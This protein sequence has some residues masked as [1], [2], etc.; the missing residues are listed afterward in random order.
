MTEPLEAGIGREARLAKEE[1]SEGVT[2]AGPAAA[3][4]VMAAT[5]A[6]EN[7]MLTVG[8]VDRNWKV[9]EDALNKVCIKNVSL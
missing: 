1:N 2:A 8:L 7:F 6:M 3:K 9:E 4:P 5:M